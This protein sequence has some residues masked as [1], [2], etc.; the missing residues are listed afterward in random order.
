MSAPAAAASAINAHV[1]LMEPSKS[2]HSGSAWIA[3]ALTNLVLETIS[4][5]YDMDVRPQK[6]E[7]FLIYSCTLRLFHQ[8]EGLSSTVIEAPVHT[9]F[10]LMLH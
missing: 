1:F 9:S 8:D 5:T 7:A 2:I 6:G 3:A 4:S 10:V